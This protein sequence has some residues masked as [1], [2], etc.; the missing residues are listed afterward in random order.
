MVCG[1]RLCVQPGRGESAAERFGIHGGQFRVCL[2]AVGYVE[3]AWERLSG[4]A[5]LVT[6]GV[7][8]GSVWQQRIW[9]EQKGR[10][11]PVPT[12]WGG[13]RCEGAG[14]PVPEPVWE[15]VSAEL[16]QCGGDVLQ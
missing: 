8:D 9:P 10:G 3:E 4:D 1:V 14:L 15:V 5:L 7:A 2:D 12:I 6:A 16:Q 11:G 13:D